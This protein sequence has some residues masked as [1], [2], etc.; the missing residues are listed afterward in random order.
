MNFNRAKTDK[1]DADIIQN[2]DGMVDDEL[3]KWA[4]ESELIKNLYQFGFVILHILALNG[5]FRIVG[6]SCRLTYK[7]VTV[8]VWT[9]TC[10][11][12]RGLEVNPGFKAA[13]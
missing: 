13:Q 8:Y 5:K 11:A 6:T 2:Y 4:P 10:P 1:K 9:T 12:L 3:K 7:D